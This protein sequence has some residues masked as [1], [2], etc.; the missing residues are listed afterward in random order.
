MIASLSRY[1]F[2]FPDLTFDIFRK[3]HQPRSP[4]LAL[5]DRQLNNG[6]TNPAT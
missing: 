5:I 2:L 4:V 3:S 6:F 1:R